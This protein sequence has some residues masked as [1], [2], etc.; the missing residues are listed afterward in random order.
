VVVY[1]QALTLV[2]MKKL[3]DSKSTI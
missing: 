2:I 3:Q 1:T